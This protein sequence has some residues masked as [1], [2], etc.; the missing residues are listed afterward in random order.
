[1]LEYKMENYKFLQKVFP[2]KNHFFVFVFML[3]YE[4]TSPLEFVGGDYEKS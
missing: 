3:G 1:M 4:K 2:D